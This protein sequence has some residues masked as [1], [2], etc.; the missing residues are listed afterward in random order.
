VHIFG[1]T[2]LKYIPSARF[3]G[4]WRGAAYS[5]VL[6][7]KGQVSYYEKLELNDIPPKQKLRMLK[8]PVADVT[9][10]QC[11]KRIEDQNISRGK[12]PLGW[13]E[14]SELLWSACSD[15]DKSHTHARPA[16]RN[17]Y[18]TYVAYDVDCVT[19]MKILHTALIRTLWKSMLTSP[20][21]PTMAVRLHLFHVNNGCSLHK[22][23]KMRSWINGVRPLVVL[24]ADAY[25]L[26]SPCDA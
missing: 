21:P 24:L 25:P 8:N 2:L 18:A 17:I 5:F 9:D 26:T 3:P 16:Q 10:L 14:Y 1:D 19:R 11:V 15:Y 20:I 4:N 22:S 23:N 6:H 12:A 13:E 7:W